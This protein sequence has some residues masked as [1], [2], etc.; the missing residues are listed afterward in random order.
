VD[1][2][3]EPLPPIVD[4]RLIEAPFEVA[5]LGQTYAVAGD[6]DSLAASASASSREVQRAER[7][8]IKHAR[9]EAKAQA[10]IDAKEAERAP[11]STSSD[12]AE[13]SHDVASEQESPSSQTD[14]PGVSTPRV[15][16]LSF[17]D[18]IDGQ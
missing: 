14:E 5:V 8:A 17:D 1:S 16:K 13:S 10:K 15:R 18:L 12:S 11:I 6:D 2:P 4:E 9:R 3:L 7:S